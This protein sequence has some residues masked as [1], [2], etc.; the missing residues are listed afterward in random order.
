MT[1]HR[2][3]ILL[4]LA[5]AIALLAAALSAITI[6]TDM[7]EFLPAGT[8]PA[9]RLILDEARTGTASGLV[10]IGLEAAPIPDLARI[11]R[12]MADTLTRTGLFQTVA[13]GQAALPQAQLDDLFAH[14]YLLAPADFSEPGLHA[15][16]ER[17]LR[18]L[19]GV[20]AP[21][22]TQFGLADPPGAFIAALKPWAAD[23]P[24]RPIDGAWFAPTRDRALLIARTNAGGMD[25]PAQE[26]ATA[27]IQSAF[28]AARP[29]PARLLVAGPAIFARDS[30][31]AIRGDVERISVLSTL[32]VA[33]L[34]WWR[35][36]RPLVIA[37]IATP[38]VASVGAA[39]LAV[40]ALFGSVHGVALGFGAT[41]LGIAV[42]YPVL[43]IGHRKHGEPAPATRARIARAFVLAVATATIGLA[44]MIF[45]GF[46]GLV[47]LGTFAAIGLVTSAILTWFAVPPLI[48]AAN[49]APTSADNPPWLPR[50][51]RLRR[52][53]LL[54]LVP[55]A[56]AALYLAVI[57]GP[58]WQ[59]DLAALSP[60]PDASRALD[61]DL[62]AD[63]GAGEMSQFIP[64]R[65]PTADAVLVRE[66]A[67]LPALDALVAAG[68]LTSIDAAARL[69]PSLETQ[70]ARQAALPDPATLAQHLDAALAGLPFRP[71]AFDPFLTSV[72]ASRD[73]SPLTQADLAGT[74]LATRLD[75]LL[76]PTADG[77]RGLILLHG[78]TNRAVL[79]ARRHLH[80]PEDRTRLRPVQLHRPRL[81][82]SRVERRGHSHPARLRPARPVDGGPHRSR[83]CHRAPPDH[84]AAHR[85]WDRALPYPPCRPPACRRSRPRLRAVLRPPAARRR[86]TRPHPAHPHHLQ[87]DD[88]ADLRPARDQPN[89]RA[90]RS[91]HHYCNRRLPRSPLRL[92]HHRRAPIFRRMTRLA[93]TALT[94]VSAIG[95]GVV[96]HGDN[97]LARRSGLRPNDF[98]PA[99]GGWIGRVPDLETYCLPNALAS[100]DCRNNRLAHLALETDGFTDAVATARARYGAHRIALVLGTSTSGILAA[101]DA[102]CD[103]NGTGALPDDFDYR[104]SQ[105]LSSLAGLVR[106]ALRLS[107]PAFVIST[108]C[109][110][111]ARAFMDAAN[112]IAAGLCDA[113]VVGGADSLCRMTL[114]GFQALELISPTPCR[115][116]GRD[117]TGISIGEAAGFALLE[118]SAG[119]PD[120]GLYLLGAGA[121][122]D[123]H[124]MSSPHPEGAGAAAAMR[125]ALAAAALD[126]ADIDWINLH[127]T[128]T[129]A[130]DAA[131]DAA[132]TA[133]FPAATPCSSTKA[134]T[135]HTLGACGILETVIADQA[136]RR[137]F[138]PGCLGIDAPDPALH[139]NIPTTTLDR[140]IECVLSNSFGFGGINCTLVLGRTH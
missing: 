44:A 29:G 64:V 83:H 106:A 21:L 74:P 102:Y 117:R 53:R 49:L 65:A 127:G 79:P 5:A 59:T 122:S 19:R 105:D 94:A 135:G 138:I 8:T 103:R 136:M 50:L 101:E 1:I 113:A 23:S 10:F 114:H 17:L 93:I 134:W 57:G 86:G 43:M 100:W 121:S 116:C 96:A 109:A 56:L 124:H 68:A 132:I 24:V 91:R 75:P 118:R 125:A 76:Q 139:A 22:V 88:P 54:A 99:I 137:G 131:E 70:R 112:L 60:I 20:A 140:P 37:A 111:S 81:A 62:R 123:G 87:R 61:H 47:Q 36:R 107:G 4:A 108:A 97:L 126:P 18:Q 51:E 95:R 6:R 16:L 27:A 63:L 115:P 119:Q 133:T 33:G 40:Q 69:L 80:R 32:L 82:P 46:P 73:L 31:R 25:I 35:F 48:V 34:L 85:R 30:A 90:A 26:A 71:A 52:Y 72:A 14:R 13:G 2:F 41:M 130:N 89:P 3:P 55:L 110:S 9:A 77:W 66:E 129:R 12:A 15:G 39:A 11:S 28:D 92:P 120:S 84:R 128:G 42:D 67:L 7:T 78:L 98:D 38:V 45:S 58:H 104:G